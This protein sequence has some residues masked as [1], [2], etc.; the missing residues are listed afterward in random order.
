MFDVISAAPVSRR[1]KIH[2]LLDGLEVIVGN[3]WLIDDT[4]PNN[5]VWGRARFCAGPPAGRR[6]CDVVL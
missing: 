4:N 6:L 1:F 2:D 5:L 3:Q